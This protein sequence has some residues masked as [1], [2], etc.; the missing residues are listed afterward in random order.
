MVD[1]YGVGQVESGVDCDCN[2]FAGADWKS[3]KAVV[4]EEMKLEFCY[5]LAVFCSVHDIEAQGFVTYLYQL[6]LEIHFCVPFYWSAYHEHDLEV[7]FYVKEV[8]L[9][10]Y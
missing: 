7:T 3:L 1:A 8:D 4:E 5:V 6:F 2:F 10:F 9:G